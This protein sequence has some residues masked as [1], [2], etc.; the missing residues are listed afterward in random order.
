M[1]WYP[2]GKGQ[3]RQEKSTINLLELETVLS[4]LQMV[5]WC[6][7]VALKVKKRRL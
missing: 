5:T 7:N 1:Q 6:I 3:S 2:N 4:R